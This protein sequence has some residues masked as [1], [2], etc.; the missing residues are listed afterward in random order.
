VADDLLFDAERQVKTLL[1]L[2]QALGLVVVEMARGLRLAASCETGLIFMWEPESGQ[3]VH[4]LEGH[5]NL[6]LRLQRLPLPGGRVGLAS[7]CGNGRLVTWDLGE[8]PKEGVGG[9]GGSGGGDIPCGDGGGDNDDHVW[10]DH[11]QT[12]RQPHWQQPC[13][14]FILLISAAWDDNMMHLPAGAGA[15]GRQQAGG[16]SHSGSGEGG[17]EG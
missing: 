2:L 4:R 16:N 8:A 15:A 1:L 9:G 12:Q 11:L 13:D 17:E 10:Y 14:L 3:L 6:I 7:V 5:N